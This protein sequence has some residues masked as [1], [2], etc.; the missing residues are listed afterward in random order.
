VLAAR[1]APSLAVELPVDVDSEIVTLRV[2]LG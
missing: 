1:A 2:A